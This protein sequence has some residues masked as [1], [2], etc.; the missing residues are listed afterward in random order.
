[1]HPTIS[2]SVVPFSCLQSSP[3][4]ES[5][6]RSQFFLSGGQSTEASA[7]VS[8]LHWIDLGLISFRI[9]WFDLLAVQGLSRVSLSPEIQKASILWCSAFFMIQLSHP[10]MSTG[11]TITLTIRTF[12]SKV[13]SLLFNTL[14]WFAIAFFPKSKCLFISWLQLPSSA[15]L[16]PRKIISVSVSTVCPSIC[17]EVKGL[18]S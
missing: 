4:S 2:S 3:A 17:H 10:Y 13:M 16:E 9:D 5:F 6:L 11:K 14:S 18:M 12:V 7:S 8:V 15:I 1:M